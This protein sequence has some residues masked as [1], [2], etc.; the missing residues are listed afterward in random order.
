VSRLVFPLPLT[1]VNNKT[2]VRKLCSP[3]LRSVRDMKSHN[4][5]A[6]AGWRGE[7][8]DSSGT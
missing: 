2:G 4:R 8:A 3:S 5:V 6:A 1:P 7:R